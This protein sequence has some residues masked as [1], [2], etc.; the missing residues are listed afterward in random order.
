MWDIYKIKI[1]EK[2]KKRWFDTHPYEIAEYS[3]DYLFTGGKEI[4]SKLF[5]EL[6]MYLCPDLEVVAELAFA[7]E[8]IHVASLILDDTPW[9]DNAAERRGRKTLHRVFSKNKA[10]LLANDVILIVLEIWKNNKPPHIEEDVWKLILTSKLQRLALGQFLDLAKKGTLIELASL[11]TGVLFELVSETV[12]LYINL[13]STFW[14]LWGN[15]IGILF[16]WMDDW[17][18]REQDIIENNRNAFNEAFDETLEKYTSIWQIIQHDIGSKWFTCPFGI[19]M[20]KYFADQLNI[21]IPSLELSLHFNKSTLWTL[22]DALCKQYILDIIKSQNIKNY[23]VI[24]E[25]YHLCT[26]IFDIPVIRLWKLEENLW[27]DYIR[28][29]IIKL[30]LPIPII[31]KI[32]KDMDREESINI[33]NDVLELDFNKILVELTNIL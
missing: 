13:D 8:C 23:K 3:W 24:E 12:A 10:L 33:L 32:H 9:M 7:I 28:Y 22:D 29:I 18:D 2:W 11:K 21:T 14:R 26:R 25:N 20:K 27:E 30:K 17:I 6:W 19:F 15:N 4:R 1:H 5:C 31:N 16:Q